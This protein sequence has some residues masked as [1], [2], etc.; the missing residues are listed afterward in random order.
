MKSIMKSGSHLKLEFAGITLL[1]MVC[2]TFEQALLRLQGEELKQN[3]TRIIGKQFHLRADSMAATVMHPERRV[4]PPLGGFQANLMFGAI[5]V[6][7][8][9][10]K[11]PTTPQQFWPSLLSFSADNFYETVSTVPEG[12]QLAICSMTHSKWWACQSPGLLNISPFFL[13]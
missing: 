12:G 9:G 3:K 1:Y 7:Q 6:W 11:P 10:P 2:L 8:T 13:P 4:P 5:Q